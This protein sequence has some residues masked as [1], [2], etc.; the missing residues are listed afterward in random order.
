MNRI[1]IL[2]LMIL[3]TGCGHRTGP[4]AHTKGQYEVGE[5][6]KIEIEDTQGISVMN[7]SSQSEGKTVKERHELFFGS[8]RK[9]LIEDAKLSVDGKKYGTL[10]PHDSITIDSK[11]TVAVN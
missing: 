3:V 9:L 10:E 6:Y 11:G 4:T 8:G 5:G 7:S 2:L 1:A